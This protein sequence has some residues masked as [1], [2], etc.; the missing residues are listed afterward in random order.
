M[1]GSMDPTPQA[2]L[3]SGHSDNTPHYSEIRAALPQ[4]SSPGCLPRG[5]GPFVLLRQLGAGGMGLVFEARHPDSVPSGALKLMRFGLFSTASEQAAFQAEIDSVARL[6]H[7]NIVPVF[8]AGEINGHPYFTMKHCRGGSLADRIAADHPHPPTSP[9]GLAFRLESGTRRLDPLQASG[10]ISTIAHAAHHA[11]KQ[12][13]LHRDLKPSNILLDDADAPLLADFG[14]ATRVGH[15]PGRT[16]VPPSIQS[17]GTFDYMAPEQINREET[18]ITAGS[19][20]WALGV[21][22]Y[23]LLTGRRPFAAP[24]RP[25]AM[26]LLR[27]REPLPPVPLATRI[28]PVLNAI[29]LR[30]LQKDLNKRYSSAEELACDLDR[31]LDSAHV[32]ASTGPRVNPDEPG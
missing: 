30:C 3:G 32:S 17:M 19:D 2:G 21:I 10:L 22:L 20:V 9:A 25:A 15:P 26:G 6:N 1:A 18:A 24:S 23:E 13:I 31:F 14:L 28:H 27:T 12:G 8:D 4:S 7:P 11:H 16:G 5:F 29:C